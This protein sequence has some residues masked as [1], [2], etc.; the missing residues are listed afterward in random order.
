M[1]IST[2]SDNNKVSPKN[3]SEIINKNLTKPNLAP[4]V[5]DYIIHTLDSSHLDFRLWY[6]V[7]PDVTPIPNISLNQNNYDQS[8]KIENKNS[9][10]E[11][12]FMSIFQLII[13]YSF[14]QN[15]LTD[16]HPAYISAL[17]QTPYN[18]TNLTNFIQKVHFFDNASK[19]TRKILKQFPVLFTHQSLPSNEIRNNKR[20]FINSLVL[21]EDLGNIFE[22][23]FCDNYSTFT[24][25]VSL[26]LSSDT[27]H[28]SLS[29]LPIPRPVFNFEIENIFESS[30]S[31]Q[32]EKND[33]KN[34]K[35]LLKSFAPISK[36][37]Y[38][39]LECL[40]HE[41][42]NNVIEAMIEVLRQYETYLFELVQKFIP[43]FPFYP[44]SSISQNYF[45]KSNQKNNI[46]EM[47][48]TEIFQNFKILTFH[49]FINRNILLDNIPIGDPLIN[50]NSMDYITPLM[51]AA[52]SLDVF[53]SEALILFGAIFSHE[54]S[55]FQAQNSD[56][57]SQNIPPSSTFPLLSPTIDLLSPSSPK[58]SQTNPSNHHF[59]HPLSEFF[60]PFISFT[61]NVENCLDNYDSDP[62]DFS[63]QL[64]A[65]YQLFLKYGLPHNVITKIPSFHIHPLFHSI[66][67]S[68]AIIDEGIEIDKNNKNGQILPPD[69]P[70]KMSLLSSYLNTT[71]RYLD[72][73][74]LAI[75]SSEQYPLRVLDLILNIDKK[76]VNNC[77]CCDM[78]HNTAYNHHKTTYNDSNDNKDRKKDSFK[79]FGTFSNIVKSFNDKN[80]KTKQNEQN[81]CHFTVMEIILSYP[82][83]D[84]TVMNEFLISMFNTLEPY[85]TINIHPL[86][87]TQALIKHTNKNAQN[88][89]QKNSHPSQKLKNSQQPPPQF[90]SVPISPLDFLNNDTLRDVISTMS[91]TDLINSIETVNLSDYFATQQLSCL[92]HLTKLEE[93]RKDIAFGREL[94]GGEE[95]S[96]RDDGQQPQSSI[97]ENNNTKRII[98]LYQSFQLLRSMALNEDGTYNIDRNIDD[99]VNDSVGH[100]E[101]KNFDQSEEVI[102]F[103]TSL[104]VQK[105][106]KKL[107]NSTSMASMGHLPGNFGKL[108]SA[109]GS[110]RDGYDVVDEESQKQP[111]KAQNEHKIDQIGSN[112]VPLDPLERL[113]ESILKSN[114]IKLDEGDVRSEFQAK[115]LFFEHLK[116]IDLNDFKQYI[117]LHD[118]INSY[119]EYNVNIGNVELG[120]ENKNRNDYKQ[121]D[122]SLAGLIQGNKSNLDDKSDDNN[123]SDDKFMKKLLSSLFSQE[124]LRQSGFKKISKNEL[125][126]ELETLIHIQKEHEV[127]LKERID[128]RVQSGKDGKGHQSADNNQNTDNTDNTDN[129]HQNINNQ[130]E[131]IAN[132]INTMVHK[133]PPQIKEFS[134]DK[135]DQKKTIFE[136]NNVENIG[137]ENNLTSLATDSTNLIS[138]MTQFSHNTIEP[139]DTIVNVE[140][141]Y[142]MGIYNTSDIRIPDIFSQLAPQHSQ[143]NNFD[144][145]NN[146]ET[147]TQN[148]SP[149]QDG[150]NDDAELNAQV[151]YNQ[152]DDVRPS[153]QS[154]N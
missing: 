15:P 7:V 139:V 152:T 19:Q 24:S 146:I 27:K 2:C 74:E 48:N 53:I 104:P 42:M 8:T 40:N 95:F 67:Q 55:L 77:L 60:Q 16:A 150:D 151:Y 58:I 106:L 85:T 101:E 21:G 13:N 126:K 123:K 87:Y 142:D 36:I 125:N 75:P 130:D 154:D 9:Q 110:G 52:C 47:E 56:K 153:N 127:L 68:N 116:G 83:L 1:D 80:E 124:N 84:T 30:K 45:K 88:Y 113:E 22:P 145:N 117:A 136:D 120:D 79:L 43:F 94:L 92:S 128:K 5:F 140:D 107:P 23:Y 14:N 131:H 31:D 144:Q 62:L 50:D 64:Y 141:G 44:K 51:N 17:S 78:Y 138:N 96:L 98:A 39:D 38:Q 37:E 129:N 105:E 35:L 108:G 59:Y 65:L 34:E 111:K 135:N 76:S 81:N 29:L 86:L 100:G 93:I 69:Q 148:M 82:Y 115:K 10:I 11:V 49:Q 134:Q 20:T 25:T 73:W 33:E 4:K 91:N 103:D 46:D 143:N 119:E 28:S 114:A 121:N 61:L 57:I 99:N 132:D 109:L 6:P 149:L 89:E 18:N 122:D 26:P 118:V 32:N 147:N 137:S 90:P 72:A 112:I 102:E 54:F 66:I 70:I 71:L 97:I 3:A 63:T 12:H 41:Y 133:L